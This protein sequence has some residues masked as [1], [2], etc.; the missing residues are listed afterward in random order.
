MKTYCSILG[1]FMFFFL[2]IVLLSRLNSAQEV[3]RTDEKPGR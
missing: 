3:A 2:G 1:P